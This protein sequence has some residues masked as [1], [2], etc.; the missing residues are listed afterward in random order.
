MHTLEP[1]KL[2][3]LIPLIRLLHQP[4]EASELI[5]PSVQVLEIFML[6]N[7]STNQEGNVVWQIHLFKHMDA[8]DT[9]Q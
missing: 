5:A 9:V 2:F 6:E 8:V 7:P 1:V 4:I 3:Y